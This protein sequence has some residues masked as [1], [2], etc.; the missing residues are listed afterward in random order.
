MEK[1]VNMTMDQIGRAKDETSHYETMSRNRSR[2]R[3]DFGMVSNKT[4][5]KKI[6]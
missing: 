5:I 1:E 3:I 6:T 2:S 4:T